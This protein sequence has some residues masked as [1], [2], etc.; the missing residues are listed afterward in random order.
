MSEDEIPEVDGSKVNDEEADLMFGYKNSGPEESPVGL[1]ADYLPEDEDFA[2]KTI[3]HEDH[4]AQLN[5][6][7]ILTQLYPELSEFEDEIDEWVDQYEK[8][9]TSVEGASRSEFTRILE[10]MSGSAAKDEEGKTPMEKL[11]STGDDE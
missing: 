9:L 2:A 10:A 6:L 8:R 5:A 1:L 4:P 3:L 11:M 7:E